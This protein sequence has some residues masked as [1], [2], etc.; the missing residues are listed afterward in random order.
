MILFEYVIVSCDSF[1]FLCVCVCDYSIISSL[2]FSISCTLFY[3]V[4]KLLPLPV[5]FLPRAILLY[6][7]RPRQFIYLVDGRMAFN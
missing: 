2:F 6:I 7:T 1:L 5:C 3:V 4:I